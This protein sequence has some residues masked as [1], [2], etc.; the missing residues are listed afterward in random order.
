LLGKDKKIVVDNGLN[1]SV[2]LKS[3]YESFNE[4]ILGLGKIEKVSTQ[5]N[6]LSIIF[7]LEGFTNFC[8]Q[9]DPQ[10][11]VPD[12]LS[13]FLRWIFQ[14]IKVELIEKSYADGYSTWAD[15]PLIS[16]YL[17]DG[18]LFIW[19]TQNMADVEIQNVVVSMYEICKKYSNKFLPQIKNDII[20][21]P[22]KLRCGIARGTVYS[23]G[24][25]NDYVGPCIN[26]SARLQKLN[27]F[28]F[29]F[30]RRGINPAN[31][32]QNYKQLFVVKRISIR[33]IG[34]GELV[35]VLKHEFDKLPREEKK[36][37]S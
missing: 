32:G 4:D 25:G 2:V 14:E 16:K 3:S 6:A 8:K 17:G 7:D 13:E 31:F 9:I 20:S 1:V 11:A 10:L 35:C 21:P 5:L 12:F 15:L 36:Q 28:S 37:F 22:S 18:L 19:D 33:G 24:D 26:M 27:P 34:D 23:V 30:S 29:T